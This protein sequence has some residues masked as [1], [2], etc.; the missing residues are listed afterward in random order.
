MM[1][2]HAF[3]G[4]RLFTYNVRRLWKNDKLFKQF[5]TFFIVRTRCHVYDCAQTTRTYIFIY[6]F[7]SLYIVNDSDR[8]NTQTQYIVKYKMYARAENNLFI[9]MFR[10]DSMK[11]PKTYYYYYCFTTLMRRVFIFCFAQ[12]DRIIRYCFKRDNGHAYIYYVL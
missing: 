4:F 6:I 8:A 12:D 1:Y 10:S 3:V 11:T 9:Y 5:R 2:I 7:Q